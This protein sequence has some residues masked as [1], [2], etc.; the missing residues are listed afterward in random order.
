[1][2]SRI[3]KIIYL[4]A[5]DLLLI[6][7]AI[8]DETDGS[9]G[10]RDL[11]RVEAAVAH[12][13]QIIYGEE[14]RANIF[15]KAAAYGFDIIKYH[16]FIDGNKRTSMTAMGVFLEV[17]GYSL[18]VGKGF[19]EKMAV[20]IVEQNMSLDDIAIWLKKHSKSRK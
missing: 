2:P 19:I 17:N 14:I 10:V 20:D 11:G 6:H 3:N 4:K 9:D 7:A 12:P 15:S 8:I 13:Q 5:E 1:M 16:P 18:S